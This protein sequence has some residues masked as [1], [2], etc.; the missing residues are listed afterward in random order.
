MKINVNDERSLIQA[1][2]KLKRRKP[3]SYPVKPDCLSKK[4]ILAYVLDALVDRKSAAVEKHLKGCGRCL[5]TMMSIQ[6]RCLDEEALALEKPDI[7]HLGGYAEKPERASGSLNISVFADYS[8]CFAVGRHSG[9]L[10]ADGYQPVALRGGGRP[11][12]E[13]AVKIRKDFE[14]KGVSVE[15]DITKGKK[16]DRYDLKLSLMRLEGSELKDVIKKERVR[17]KGKGIRKDAVTDKRGECVFSNLSYGSYEAAVGKGISIKVDVK[18]KG[19]KA[20]KPQKKGLKRAAKRRKL[21]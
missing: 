19:K 1:L 9:V 13:K 15:V 8:G 4:T 12:K 2:L 21:S 10:L 3:A 16:I 14:D 17:L 11:L 18:R 20:A 6:K 5:L 7:S